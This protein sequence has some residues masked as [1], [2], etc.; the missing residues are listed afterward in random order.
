MPDKTASV[1]KRKYGLGWMNGKQR[2]RV[3]TILTACLWQSKT[4]PLMRKQK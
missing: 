2:K 4:S 1:K 3:V